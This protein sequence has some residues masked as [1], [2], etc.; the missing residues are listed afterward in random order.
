MKNTTTTYLVIIVCSILFINKGFSQAKTKTTATI[1]LL[2]DEG[3]SKEPLDIVYKSN[4]WGPSA[5][6]IEDKKVE[7]DER[8]TYKVNFE[9]SEKLCYFYFR[10][11][12]NTKLRL[13]TSDLNFIEPGDSVVMRVQKDSLVFSGKGAEKF[14]CI[15]TINKQLKRYQRK[16]VD[17]ILLDERKNGI[18]P[19]KD[20][21]DLITSLEAVKTT[22][23]NRY[24]DELQIRKLLNTHKSGISKFINDV[25]KA[26]VLGETASNAEQSFLYYYDVIGV[27]EN[28]NNGAGQRTLIDFYETQ[29]PVDFANVSPAALAVSDWYIY[30]RIMGLRIS[31]LIDDGRFPL[32]NLSPNQLILDRLITMYL[33]S[34]YNY[35]FLNGPVLIGQ[36]LKVVRTGYCRDTLRQLKNNQGVGALAYN[37]SLPDSSGKKVQ[38][39][40][41]KGKAVMMDF[42]F[43]GCSACRE[44]NS[45]MTNVIAAFK[46]NKN[47][48]FLSV[49][50][51]KDKEMWKKSL[52]SHLYTHEG[53]VDLYTDGKASMHPIIGHYNIGSYPTQLLIDKSGKILSSQIPKPYNKENEARLID[54]LTNA[55]K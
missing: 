25:I 13:P 38:M 52:D 27:V 8:N 12:T 43:T 45:R 30:Y 44:L 14:T 23:K 15:Y 55:S 4:E 19:R 6:G 41:F 36:S 2:Y 24:S 17:S 21:L 39:S 29:K 22:Y 28:K 50:V 33:S 37:F 35:E 20:K 42:F 5:F 16:R 48:V 18:K 26:N 11:R 49:S 54:I 10:K 3:V 53:S 47:I 51:D 34:Y 1:T 9:N 40:N 7:P 31:K 32:V 46:G